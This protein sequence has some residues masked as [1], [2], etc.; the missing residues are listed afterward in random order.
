LFT[1]LARDYRDISHGR[2]LVVASLENGSLIAKLRDLALLAVPH[3]QDA[4]EVAKGAKAIADLAKLLRDW[5]GR[6]K[7]G[8]VKRELYRPGRKKRGAPS[9]E[10]ILKIAANSRSHVRV[11]HT[12]AKGEAFEV[13]LTPIEAIQAR[14]K[15]LAELDSVSRDVNAP[16]DRLAVP[17]VQTALQRL[18]HA[19]TEGLSSQELEAI[20]ETMVKVLLTAGLS[21]FLD[22][23]ASDLDHRGLHKLA[24]SVRQQIRTSHGKHEPPLSTT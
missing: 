22:Q 19:E 24:S 21:P 14:E 16:S 2:V 8:R 1:A 6:V 7:T 12:T 13:E 20:V 4:V 3:L 18:I 10:A 9:I 5:L 15:A 23:I 17:V 11:K